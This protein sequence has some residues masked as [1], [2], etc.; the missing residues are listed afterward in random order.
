MSTAAT[1]DT[2]VD[3]LKLPNT[4]EHCSDSAVDDSTPYP[5]NAL[6]SPHR[7]WN[8]ATV[9]GII[10]R[11]LPQ[12]PVLKS[13]SQMGHTQPEVVAR[14]AALKDLTYRVTN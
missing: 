4:T 6:S 7:S 10:N 13:P 5:N 1:G 11:N 8:P 2:C 3:Q 12:P 14:F 9:H